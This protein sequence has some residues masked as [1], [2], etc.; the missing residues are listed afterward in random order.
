MICFDVCIGSCVHTQSTSGSFQCIV[1]TTHPNHWM[2]VVDFAFDPIPE[3]IRFA[4]GPIVFRGSV[5]TEKTDNKMWI[6][7]KEV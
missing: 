3:S 2:T 1:T 4:G 5:L 6:I 7:M